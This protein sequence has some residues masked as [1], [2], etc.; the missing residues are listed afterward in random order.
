M[1]IVERHGAGERPAIASA[2]GW[3]RAETRRRVAAGWLVV[4]ACAAILSGCVRPQER[5]EINDKTKFSQEEYGVKASPRVTVAKKVQKG[6]GRYVVGKP[7]KI[8]NKWYKPKEDPNYAAVGLASWYGPNFH[9]RKTANGEIFDQYAIS[10]AH[11]TMPL[12]SYA[13]VTNLDTGT[14]LIVRVNDRGPFHSGRVIDL[15]ARAAQMLGYADNGVA[16]VKVEY[17]GKARIDGHDERFLMA[18]YRT[19]GAPD[20]EPGATMPGTMLAMADEP[21]PDGPVPAE[22]VAGVP[23]VEPVQVAF[24]ASIP[25]PLSRPATF[26]GIAF[27]ITAPEPILTAA[28]VPLGFAPEA[29]A[30]RRIVAAFADVE[31]RPVAA[32]PA[33]DGVRPDTG[34][35]VVVRL[36][37]FGEAGHAEYVRQ[38]VADLG[39]TAM[40]RVNPDAGSGWE[41]RLLVGGDVAE[42]VL[43]I[44]RD[45]GLTGAAIITR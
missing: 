38:I 28:I 37:M 33:V 27:D 25:V 29:V 7:Y 42:A 1:R 26:D 36:G 32:L 44:A 18:S 4:A 41:V 24:A 16:S 6:G 10:A 19:P 13:R 40:R 34:R 30:N 31:R 9:G 15:S 3:P 5:A 8:R 14:S 35:T 22:P 11:P 2:S 45:R 21:V 43:A 23:P 12:P 17:V 39:M 20:I